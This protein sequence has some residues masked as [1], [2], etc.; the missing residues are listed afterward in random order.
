MVTY[1]GRVAQ[2][3][4]FVV[5]RR[6]SLKPSRPCPRLGSPTATV[7]CEGSIDFVRSLAPDGLSVLGHVLTIAGW[8]AVD[9]K[10]GLAA[11]A[12]YV[13]IRDERG[14]FQFVAT[15]PTPRPDVAQYFK[16]SFARDVGFSTSILVEHLHGAYQ[17]GMARSVNGTLE[18]CDNLRRPILIP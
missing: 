17:I 7:A 11:D 13:T 8:V 16:R 14:E 9:G 18:M 10:A 6:R 1:D 2:P 4:A 3:E 12:I 15:R 5:H